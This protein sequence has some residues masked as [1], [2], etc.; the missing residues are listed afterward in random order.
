MNWRQALIFGAAVCAALAVVVTLKFGPR[1]Y[2]RMR[3][4]QLQGRQVYDEHADT[5]ALF[6]A[7]L[8][9]AN[10]E[11][12]RVLVIMGGNWC[13]WCL[14]LD[15]L[16]HR[17]ERLHGYLTQH[18]VL[19]KLDS[20]AAHGLDEAWGQP[21]HNGVPVLIFLDDKGV[22]RHVQESVS[23]ELWGGKILGHDAERVLDV[24]KRWS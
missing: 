10:R 6:N 8:A 24:L 14:A 22:V 17:N 9:Q 15:D 16:M 13:Q 1:Y 4:S 12:K 19:V 7:G 21:S 20:A 5:Q 18:Y 3:V 23:L 11:H 2:N